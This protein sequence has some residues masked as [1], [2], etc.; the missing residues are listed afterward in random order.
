MSISG[1]ERSRTILFV[2]LGTHPELATLASR[3]EDLVPGLRIVGIGADDTTPRDVGEQV[4]HEKDVALGAYDQ[5][6]SRQLYVDPDLYL[7][8]ISKEGQLLRMAE[9]VARQDV[10][11]I[12]QPKFPVAEFVHDVDGT[13]QLLLRQ[14]SFWDWIIRHH[15]ID[16][17]I[18]Q[19]I[20]HN[21]WDAALHA[22]VTARRVPSM[23]F[24]NV[25]PF[26]T[27]VYI[28]EDP[29]D[30]GNLRFGKSIL[31]EANRRYGLV[32]DSVN[33]QSV[34]W[35]RVST[36]EAKKGRLSGSTAAVSVSS[37]AKSLVADPRI[38]LR[39]ITRSVGRRRELKGTSADYE[40]VTSEHGLPQRFVFIE[41]QRAANMT[42]HVKGY[43]YADAREMIA[44]IAFSLPN[45]TQLVVRESSRTGSSRGPR[46]ELFWT[47]IAAIPRVIV[48]SSNIDTNEI[49]EK[50]LAIVELGY[51]SLAL[52]AMNNN[53]PVVVL[54]LTHLH[55]APNVHVVAES[56]R[57]AEV[58]NG[59]CS[60]PSSRRGE[61]ESTTQALRDWADIARSATLEG[62]LSSFRDPNE[63][64]DETGNR[65]VGNTA[66]VIAA[67]CELRLHGKGR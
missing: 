67:W 17:V 47:Q 23:C 22:V 16:G 38:A 15:K 32:A 33:R 25:L 31:N 4:V 18:F 26:I 61:T 42:T 11:S 46:R 2:K 3:V 52:E 37:R 39:K 27:S 10:F 41:L 1:I 54:G 12:H 57:L 20:P 45:D 28:Y 65:L 5:W 56:S 9:R 40:S 8:I 30:M 44:H 35:R 19:N 24:H 49:L 7:Q 14:I 60:S 53:V 66:A 51:S 34:M 36:S 29:N 48:V 13:T 50:S 58:L 64:D 6:W 59:V 43:M 55:G 21:F 63:A 62:R